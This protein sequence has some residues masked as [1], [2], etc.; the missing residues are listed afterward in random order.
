M[1]VVPSV[2]RKSRFRVPKMFQLLD[3]PYARH[4]LRRL[5]CEGALGVWVYGSRR[6]EAFMAKPTSAC[7]EV[8]PELEELLVL[9]F[10]ARVELKADALFVDERTCAADRIP[11]E[12]RDRPSLL[13]PIAIHTRERAL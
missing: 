11:R 5:N 1:V 3:P 7:H 2:P 13:A 6:V 9:A 10:D 8:V 12:I 4:S